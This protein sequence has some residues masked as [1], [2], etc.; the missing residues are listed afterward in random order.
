MSFEYANPEAFALVKRL[1]ADNA[2]QAQVYIE[3]LITDVKVLFKQ[4]DLNITSIHGRQKHLYSVYRKL[5]KTEG[6]ITKIYDLTALR[7]IVP[8][9]SDCYQVLGILHQAY[10]PLIYRIKDYI[11]V[12]K[13]N[14]YRSLHTSRLKRQCQRRQQ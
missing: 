11:A 10:K 5:T 7:I 1:V 3:D 6:D 14:G 12:P 8:T 9:I 4:H 2:P 13:P